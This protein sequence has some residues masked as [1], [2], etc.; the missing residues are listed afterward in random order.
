MPKIRGVKKIF[1][2]VNILFRGVITDIWGGSTPLHPPENPS[3]DSYLY[4]NDA[5][6][7]NNI[8]EQLRVVAILSKSCPHYDVCAKPV[9]STTFHKPMMRIRGTV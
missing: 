8:P 6:H 4:H 7:Q 5:I 3:M 2:R 1:G 9:M